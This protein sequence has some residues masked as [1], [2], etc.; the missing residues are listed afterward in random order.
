MTKY[1]TLN[2]CLDFKFKLKWLVNKEVGILGLGFE[3]NLKPKYLG[4]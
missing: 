2:V 1:W 3:P 4:L